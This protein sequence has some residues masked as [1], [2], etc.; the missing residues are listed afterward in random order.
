M[1][2]PIL[3]I[4]NTSQILLKGHN[5]AEHKECVTPHPALEVSNCY[6]GIL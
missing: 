2:K 6:G 1:F 5:T 3:A 4:Q